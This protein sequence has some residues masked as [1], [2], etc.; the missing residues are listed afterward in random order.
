M[1]LASISSLWDAA[2]RTLIR[3]PGTILS[4]ILAATVA[5]GLIDD[6]PAPEKS[7]H[8]LMV[9]ALGIPLFTALRLF[10]EK[11]PWGRPLSLYWILL[12]GGVVF[13]FL[14]WQ[15]LNH[16]PGDSRYLRHFQISLALH[17]A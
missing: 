2:R 13:L 10:W 15:L 9:V 1:R 4:G 7:I 3:F 17:L 6:Q 8:M 11:S 14:Y 16:D 12:G 5:I